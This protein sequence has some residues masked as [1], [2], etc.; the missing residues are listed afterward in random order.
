MFIQAAKQ[1]AFNFKLQQLFNY[2]K[3]KFTHD[4]KMTSYYIVYNFTANLKPLEIIQSFQRN[5]QKKETLF[6]MSYHEKN[7]GQ[8]EKPLITVG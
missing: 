7:F 4:Q 5:F 8:Q 2:K 3:Q 6:K 1:M